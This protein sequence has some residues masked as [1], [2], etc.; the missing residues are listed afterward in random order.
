MGRLKAQQYKRY[1]AS[2]IKILDGVGQ[3][4]LWWDNTQTDPAINIYTRAAAS[5]SWDNTQT[6]P[7]IT[8][9]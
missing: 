2:G 1:I 9:R 3:L 4:F 5:L 6:D 8:V 7:A